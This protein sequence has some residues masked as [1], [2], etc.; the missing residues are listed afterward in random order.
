[1]RQKTEEITDIHKTC[2]L[3]NLDLL[4][5]QPHSL[6]LFKVLNRLQRFFLNLYNIIKVQ[7]INNILVVLFLK[8][9]S[10]KTLHGAAKG[11]FLNNIQVLNGWGRLLDKD[12]FHYV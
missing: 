5:I 4:D 9:H 6:N 1:M 7:G 10:L 3:K 2:T 8:S 11:M 12:Y